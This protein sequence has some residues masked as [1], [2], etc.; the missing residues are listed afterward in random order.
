M[1]KDFE[2]V[3]E[4]LDQAA[5]AVADHLKCPE[6]IGLSIIEFLANL[7]AEMGNSH[8]KMADAYRKRMAQR[9]DN[10]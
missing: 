7:H 3:V 9:L 1:D 2:Q 6:G 4:E 5:L 10:V 8:I